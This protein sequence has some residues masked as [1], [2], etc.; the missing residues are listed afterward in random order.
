MEL[1]TTALHALLAC[2]ICVTLPA[3]DPAAGDKAA[4]STEFASAIA[5]N[6]L[7]AVA[8]AAYPVT[9]D[10]E[11]GA[12][13]LRISE[14][15]GTGDPEYD[16]R[17]PAAA[18]AGAS[19]QQLVIWWADDNTGGLVDEENEIFSQSLRPSAIFADGFESG[20]TTAWSLTVP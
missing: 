20:D 15:G 9:I 18:Y 7:E 6:D 13:D 3:A 2:C 16:A 12:N 10:P 14:M 5:V 11:I 8:A 19:N 4:I 17:W 1:Q